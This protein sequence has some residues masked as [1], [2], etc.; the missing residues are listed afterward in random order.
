MADD[1]YDIIRDMK[2]DERGSEPEDLIQPGLEVQV[3]FRLR[4]AE[5]D[6]LKAL[7]DRAGVGPST[8][9]RLIVQRYLAEHPPEVKKQGKG[10]RHE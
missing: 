3:S 2:K 9:A 10:G 8:L 4:P 6:G 7:A 5:A 1:L